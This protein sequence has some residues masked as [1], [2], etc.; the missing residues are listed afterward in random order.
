M[1]DDLQKKQEGVDDIF[2]D[3]DS[4]DPSQ[5]AKNPLGQKSTTA[6][7]IKTEDTEKK[8]AD[9]LAS[10]FGEEKES[11]SGI[12]KKVFIIIFV[13]ALIGAGA[14]FVYSQILVPNSS[15]V[16]S[17][18]L[19]GQSSL[20]TD[21]SEANSNDLDPVLSDDEV[22]APDQDVFNDPAID[23]DLA[24]DDDLVIDDDLAGG[25][26][27]PEELLK[28]LD[29]DGDGLSD[30]EEMYTYITDPYNPDT[31]SD[32]LSDYEEVMIFGTDPLSPDTDGDTYFDGEEVM[33]G[34]NPLGE[35]VLN[36]ELFKNSEL[37]FDRFPSLVEKLGL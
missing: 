2:A 1:F 4:V 20:G 34:Y 11:G 23:D 24:G 28:N 29:S 22:D 31:D 3:T 12:L 8:I 27:S 33:S 9:N 26:A 36:P 6:S 13:L 5:G 35:G 19:D 18:N 37:F 14:Y 17:E 7:P 32:G 16:D 10:D 25:E 30:Y 21:D 15:Q